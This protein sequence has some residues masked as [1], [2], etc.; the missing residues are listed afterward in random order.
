MHKIYEEKGFFNLINQLP[1]ILYS[2]LISAFINMLMKKLALSGMEVIELKK[3]KDK[4]EALQK[5]CDL[6]K[7]LTIRFNFFFIV[8]LIFLIFFGIIYLHFVQFI[9]ILK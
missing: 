2:T 3:K 1:Q 5:S 6:Y 7:I 4:E 9:K 8:A